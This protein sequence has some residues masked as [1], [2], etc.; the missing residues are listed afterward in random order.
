M[1]A[2]QPGSILN[3]VLLIAF[4][5]GGWFLAA[6]M[7]PPRKVSVV[8]AAVESGGPAH[9]PGVFAGDARRMLEAK[10]AGAAEFDEFALRYGAGSP[11]LTLLTLPLLEKW[12][13]SSPADASAII[14]RCLQQ[15]PENLPHLFHCLAE[16]APSDPAALLASVPPGPL[17]EPCARALGSGLG[18][19]ARGLPPELLA[20]LPRHERSA[21][22]RE[23]HRAR[24]VNDYAAASSAAAALTDA[25][26]RESAVAGVLAARAGADPALTLSSST[27][28]P[29]FA[30][31]A[32]EALAEWSARD[33][34]AAWEFAASLQNDPRLPTIAAA[35]V[36]AEAGRR[37]LSESVSDMTALLDRFFPRGIPVEPLTALIEAL[38]GEKSTVAQKFCDS[39][40][41]ETRK[42]AG[43]LLFDTFC[44]T[45]PDAAWRLAGA[46]VQ[47]TEAKDNRGT[48][49]WSNAT[50]RAFATPQQRLEAGFP[51][52]TDMIH[53]AHSWIHSDPP[54][55]IA[56]F[57][58]PG[59]PVELQK[60]IVQTSLSAHGG[61][62]P[63][64]QLL[65][66]GKSQPD[67]ILH[68]IEGLAG[69]TAKPK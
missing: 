24:A 47:Q 42:I 66:W 57:C 31:L 16:A 10:T 26:D 19:T 62:V 11:E 2:A 23:W 40:P 30:K 33:S 6:W 36:R 5:C 8:V 17:Y 65:E 39:L 9:Q 22:L 45:D 37:R 21:F 18:G 35:M 55:A 59:V 34:A 27:V 20:K 7:K 64:A 52:L 58:A 3:L 67:H 49:T 29:D 14:A 51:D 44:R 32:S 46:L 4:G 43:V 25:D 60:L 69:E 1:P 68:T 38:A 56:N 15:A 53:L 61:A 41:P 63:A 54:A 48:H 13:A 12:A 28:R 50:T